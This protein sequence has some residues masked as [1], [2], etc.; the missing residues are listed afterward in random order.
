MVTAKDIIVR[1][2]LVLACV[3]SAEL[4]T[5][6]LKL[7]SHTAFNFPH[8]VYFQESWLDQRHRK[9]KISLR[10]IIMAYSPLT[11]TQRRPSSQR[12]IPKATAREYAFTPPSPP[13]SPPLTPSQRARSRRRQ[14]PR[15]NRRSRSWRGTSSF[16]L[17]LHER[18]N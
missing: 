8:K 4:R 9:T 15:Q 1:P 16:G 10:K 7:H 18:G 14:R 5:S 13:S 6:L 11:S 17:R 2:I 3:D 12:Q